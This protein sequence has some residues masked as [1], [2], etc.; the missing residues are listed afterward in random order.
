MITAGVDVGSLTAKAV[1]WDAAACRLLGD[2]L[3]PTASSPEGA[4]QEAYARALTAAHLRSEDVSAVVGT[5]YGRVSLSF[6]ERRVTEI[7]CHARGVHSL[8]PGTRTIIDV[9]GQDSKVIRCDEG[10]RALDFEM[11]DRC[12]AGTGRFLE[13]MAQALGTDLGGLTAMALTAPQAAR[14]SSTCTVFAES[15][16]VGLLAHGVSPAE[17]AAGLCEA[18]AQRVAAMVWRLGLVEEVTFTGGVALNEAV[19]QALERQLDTGLRVPQYPQLTGALGA[20]I[21]AAESG[22]G[23]IGE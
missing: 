12:A 6:V 5:G 23:A 11:N 15:E 1:V 18:V 19:R 20:A 21:I 16:V 2:G 14:L 8:L 3:L 4:G 7:T 22:V 9:G 10:G 13:V 17:V